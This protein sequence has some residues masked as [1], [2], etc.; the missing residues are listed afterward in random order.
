MQLQELTCPDDLL[1]GVMNGAF[2][3]NTKYNTIS[4]KDNTLKSLE[5]LGQVDP[6]AD[7]CIQ[8][9]SFVCLYKS[10]GHMKVQKLDRWYH[11]SNHAAEGEALKPT[12]G[13]LKLHIQQAHF[14][15]KKVIHSFSHLFSM[16]G[17]YFRVMGF[18]TTVQCLNH[19]APKTVMNQ[20]GA[21]VTVKK[22]LV[23]QSKHN[24]ITFDRYG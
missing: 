17:N 6:S 2:E 4:Y 3:Y 18:N 7:I 16:A 8:L 5:S 19:P 24:R 22:I 10:K 15:A 23:Q 9:E 13:L 12:M 11:Y 20:T 1:V 14:I 21:A